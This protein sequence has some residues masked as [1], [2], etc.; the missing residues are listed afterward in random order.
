VRTSDR[1]VSRALGAACALALSLPLA[2]AAAV[3]GDV[4]VVLS[5]ARVVVGEHGAEQLV[6]TDAVHPGDVVEYRATYTNQGDGAVRG[7]AATLPIPAG[8]RYVGPTV[9]MER[10]EASTDGVEF[11][12]VP[13][14]RTVIGPDGRERTEEVPASEY[15]ALRWQIGE[16]AA[17]ASRSV[18]ARVVVPS[19]RTAQ[20]APA[21]LALH[22]V[23]ADAERVA[24]RAE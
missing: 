6:T 11:A 3:A 23:P 2:P 14:R 9:T 18:A 10:V 20:Q 12:P 5:A 16:L 15:R 24:L 1:L 13:L 17:N 4:A 7:L 19:V 21:P 22:P 8:T